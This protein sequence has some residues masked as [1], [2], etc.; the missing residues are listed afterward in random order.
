M[1]YNF[2]EVFLL[3]LLV[4]TETVVSSFQKNFLLRFNSLKALIFQ[5]Q[6]FSWHNCMIFFFTFSKVTHLYAF[7]ISFSF[8]LNFHLATNSM[9]TNNMQITSCII[10]LGDSGTYQSQISYSFEQFRWKSEDSGSQRRTEALKDL[11][12]LRTS[13][14]K[15]F[16]QH[17]AT[18]RR[19]IFQYVENI[20]SWFSIFR[21]IYSF[22]ICLSSY[23]DNRC[24]K[25]YIF[26]LLRKVKSFYFVFQS[27]AIVCDNL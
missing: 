23:H 22:T 13:L 3:S 18:I 17:C 8:R 9:Q 11:N 25:F 16:W 27:K 19:S 20:I 15:T 24:L 10:I 7:I 5:R 4:W 14:Y 6:L 2:F 12:F 21:C 26:A 1:F